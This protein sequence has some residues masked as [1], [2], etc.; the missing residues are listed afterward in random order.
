V[1]ASAGQLEQFPGLGHQPTALEN[2]GYR[3]IL[4]N[5]CRV[6]YRVDQCQNV[7]IMN[8]MRCGRQ[9]RQYLLNERSQNTN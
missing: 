4:V 5:P 8:V 9:L 7:Y 3:E 1:F 2:T 6:I